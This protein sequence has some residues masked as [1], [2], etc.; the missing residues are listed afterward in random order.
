MFVWNE[1]W[2]ATRVENVIEPDLEIV[3]PHHHLWEHEGM[4]PYLLPD[5]H[6][7][8][9]GGHRVTG[10]VFVDCTWG[11]RTVGPE[12]LRPV[13]ETETV[14][15]ASRQGGEGSVIRGIVGFADLTLADAA[16]EVVDAHIEAGQG[17]FS[18][19][20]HATAHDDDRRISRSHTRP[21]AGLMADPAFRRGVAELAKRDLSFD[22][23]LFHR[24][25]PELTSLARALPDNRFVLDH[26]GG[27]LG[28][29]PYAGQRDEILAQWRI[30]VVE[31][32]SCPNVFVK[33][34]GI[35]MVIFGLGF[36]RQPLPPSSD[37]LVAAWGGPMRHVIETFGVER[38]MFESNFPVDKMSCSYVTLWN[39]FKKVSKG[40]SANEK[41]WLFRQT[42]ESF[43][44]LK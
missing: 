30:D 36:E 8:T 42:A 7:D 6:A 40:A 29:G 9:G 17:R 28:T 33:V 39:A 4:T 14:V 43:Y 26:L 44:R 3:D 5:L 16:G 2:L 37:E 1:D 19:I 13:G 25:I 15:E 24:Q 12:H 38:C 27:I 35:G 20:R 22:A 41:A 10:T 34:G 11:Y 23:W 18:G 31:L 21:R 32:A